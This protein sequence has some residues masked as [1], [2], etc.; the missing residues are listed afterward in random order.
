M[1]Q[2]L[3]YLQVDRNTIVQPIPENQKEDNLDAAVTA[4]TAEEEKKP[5]FTWSN[6]KEEVK[7]LFFFS[8][9]ILCLFRY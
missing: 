3:Y 1:P 7:T 2:L 8:K 5:Q 6:S 9:N 4:T